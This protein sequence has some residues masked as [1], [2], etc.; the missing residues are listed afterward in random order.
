MIVDVDLLPDHVTTR[1]HP[2]RD[3]VVA[4]LVRHPKTH[5]RGE[6]QKTSHFSTWTSSSLSLTLTLT[7]NHNQISNIFIHKKVAWIS[8]TRYDIYVLYARKIYFTTQRKATEL[9][10]I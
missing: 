9:L 5:K 4:R 7:F 3:M 1:G 10:V 6:Q 8:A 2:Y